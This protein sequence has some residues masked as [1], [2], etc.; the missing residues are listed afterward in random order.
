MHFF[1]HWSPD[2]ETGQRLK[3]FPGA[4]AHVSLSRLSLPLSAAENIVN[5]P[6][7]TSMHMFRFWTNT[8]ATP[9]AS[10]L[11]SSPGPGACNWVQELE[12]RYTGVPLTVM[13]HVQLLYTVHYIKRNNC[14]MISSMQLYNSCSVERLLTRLSVSSMISLQGKGAAIW[15]WP[16]SFAACNLMYCYAYMRI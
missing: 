14:T 9:C 7:V 11:F 16:A 3:R 10:I 13:L 2:S 1:P 6:Q 15:P 8:I 4:A 5:T 12:S